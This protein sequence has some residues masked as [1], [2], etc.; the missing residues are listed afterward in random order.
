MIARRD[1]LGGRP[2]PD[3]GGKC[4]ARKAHSAS[5][6]SLEYRSPL[7]ACC[8]RV[9]SVHMCFSGDALQHRMNHKSLISN[10][11]FSG[12]TLRVCTETKSVESM[13]CY[14]HPSFRRKVE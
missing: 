5:V 4:G 7:R 3:R 14:F 8:A 6:I 2:S 12:Q 11:L 1:H 9:I 13:N 10:N